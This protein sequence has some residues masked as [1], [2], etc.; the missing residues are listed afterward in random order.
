[1]RPGGEMSEH[2]TSAAYRGQSVTVMGGLGFIGSTLVRALLAGGARVTVVDSM[3]PQHGGNRF[4]LADVADRVDIHVLDGADTSAMR[5]HVRDRS[6]VFNLAGQVSHI[7]SMANPAGDLASNCGA[8]LGALEA[9]R[10][11][12]SGARIVF[13]STRQVYG[14]SRDG[15][16]DETHAV[17]PVDING[18]HKVAAEEYHRLYAEV[19]G[20]NSVVLRL[21]NIYGPRQLL[22][23]ARQGFVA[24]FVR[25][26]LLGEEIPLYAPGTQTRDFCYVDDAVDAILRVGMRGRVGCEVFNVGGSDTRSLKDFTETLLRIA[27]TG[28]MRLVEYP[29]DRKAIEVGSIEISDQRLRLTTGWVPSV[30]VEEGLARMIAYYRANARHYLESCE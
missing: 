23:H 19:H 1:M 14:R 22:R 10:L 29:A 4:N 25:L 13:T 27:G 11:E 5:R 12:Q 6:V 28:S 17:R 30:S 9:V 20:V 21:T 8:A 24:W 18:I 15:R 16:I 26:A 2:D 7:D 3:H